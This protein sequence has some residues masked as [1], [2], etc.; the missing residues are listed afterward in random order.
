MHL[1]PNH[2]RDAPI[3]H[4]RLTA[5]TTSSNSL[6]APGTGYA[7]I[8]FYLWCSAS[9]ISSIQF[10]NGTGGSGLFELKTGTAQTVEIN[11]WEEPSNLS[12]NKCPILETVAG[13]GVHDIHVWM[14]KVRNGAGQ[15]ATGL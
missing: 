1:V 11:F 3:K 4:L 10:V 9:G 5:A 2:E 13:I 15:S 6:A 8:P 12:S 7:Y 14:K